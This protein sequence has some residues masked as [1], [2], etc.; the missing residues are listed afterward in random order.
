VIAM[1]A[2]WVEAEEALHSKAEIRR[3]PAA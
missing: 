1:L 3:A 2:D